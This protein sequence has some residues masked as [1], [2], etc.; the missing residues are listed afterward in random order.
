MTYDTVTDN[1]QLTVEQNEEVII[2]ESVLYFN[3]HIYLY[4]LFL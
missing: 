4:Y 3:Q 2:L 1:E